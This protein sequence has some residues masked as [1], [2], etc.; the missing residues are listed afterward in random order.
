MTYKLTVWNVAAIMTCW[1]VR[2]RRDESGRSYITGFDGVE[3]RL[4]IEGHVLLEDE[5]DAPLLL[6]SPRLLVF[7]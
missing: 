7:A 3:R 6:A 5:R 1:V 4:E 2:Y